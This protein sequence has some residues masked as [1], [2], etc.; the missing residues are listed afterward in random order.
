MVK[1]ERRLDI[2]QHTGIN[3]S[4]LP[5]QHGFAFLRSF[6]TD[7]SN[8]VDS[9]W[10][11]QGCTRDAFTREPQS[12]VGTTSIGGIGFSGR[13]LYAQWQNAIMARIKPS[14]YRNRDTK[15]I[16]L[17][18]N[19]MKENAPLPLFQKMPPIA[20]NAFNASYMGYPKAPTPK[21]PVFYIP[22]DVDIAKGKDGTTYIKDYYAMR[23]LGNFGYILVGGGK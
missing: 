19:A 2:C 12:I 3:A 1:I 15:E 23:R 20:D 8:Y 10:G 6:L 14:M 22:V 17:A 4:G 7:Q 5:H 16:G 18:I 13:N 9:T 21:E 11:G